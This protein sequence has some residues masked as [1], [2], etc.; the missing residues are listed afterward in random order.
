MPQ[1]K[2]HHARRPQQRARK[3]RHP[4]GATASR[5]PAPA[6]PASGRARFEA[7]S[8]RALTTLHRLPRWVLPVVLAV[9]LLL[10][11]ALPSRWAGLL[12]LLLAAFL[13]WLLALAWPLVDARGRILRSVVVLALLVAGVLRLL[14]SS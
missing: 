3:S 10:G 12:L 13:G 4:A 1:S 7:R 2:L 6:K 5:T 8:A 11:L 14:S 9:V